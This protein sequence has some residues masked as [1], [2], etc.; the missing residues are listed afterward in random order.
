MKSFSLAAVGVFS[1]CGGRIA[2]GGAD[3]ILSY[4]GPAGGVLGSDLSARSM[5]ALL[6]WAPSAEAGARSSEQRGMHLSLTRFKTLMSSISASVWLRRRRARS[7]SYDRASMGVMI[8]L[9]RSGIVDA[10]KNQVKIT[11]DPGRCPLLL[12]P[13]HGTMR[14]WPVCHGRLYARKELKTGLEFDFKSSPLISTRCE[15]P[16]EGGRTA[17]TDLSV[18]ETSVSEV[19]VKLQKIGDVQ[20]PPDLG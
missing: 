18:A 11:K 20:L 9:M 10:G 5:W 7:G 4:N 14:P 2:V 3:T 13:N 1:V 8:P 17:A 16:C 12:R 15:L 6:H 19:A